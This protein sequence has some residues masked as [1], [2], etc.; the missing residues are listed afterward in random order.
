MLPEKP[1]K[2]DAM[3][4]LFA[5]VLICIFMG[6]LASPMVALLS[7]P[8]KADT[9][10]GLVL[11]TAALGLFAGA[12]WIL[13]RRWRIE[14]FVRDFVI[15]LICFY[16]GMILAWWA[17]RVRGEPAALENSPAHILLAVISFQG[18][19][20]W[21][22]HRF[23]G[24]HR[25]GWAEAFGFRMDCGRAVLLGFAAALLFLPVGW[26]LQWASSWVMERFHFQPQEQQAVHVL[27]AIE[28]WANRIVLGIAVSL[29]A[30]V[31]EEV[32]FRGILYPAIRQ[33]GWPRLAWWGT[34]FLFA[35]IH[36]NLAAFMPLTV[37]A[38]CL[39]WLYEKTKNLVAPITV[40]ILFNG[41]N[42]AAIFLGDSFNR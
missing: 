27:R 17:M 11:I 3:L 4:R 12:L 20:L 34:S 42:F 6:T 37:L 5:R 28:G 39:I 35:A 36:L 32:L 40:H 25:I 18:V 41:M 14:T 33:K 24:E 15:L 9:V 16:G 26:G 2:A 38:L 30:P 29:V 1:W 8:R 13:G 23:L 7:G 19:T 22:V 21:L 31:G 10:A